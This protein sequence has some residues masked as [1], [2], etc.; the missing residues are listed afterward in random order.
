MTTNYPIRRIP[1]TIKWF[2]LIHIFL[3]YKM[4]CL[5]RHT[6][7]IVGDF[8]AR[9]HAPQNTGKIVGDF[10]ARKHAPQ[11]MGKIVGDFSARK[12]APLN[13]KEY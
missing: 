9:K 6:D 11:N 3:N 10:S 8:S 5:S 13:F 2:N 1:N 4:R 12:H 7:K